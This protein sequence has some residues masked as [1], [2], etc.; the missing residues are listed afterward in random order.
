MAIR[1]HLLR[2]DNPGAVGLNGRV[3]TV[4][5]SEAGRSLL[6]EAVESFNWIVPVGGYVVCTCSPSMGP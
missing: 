5:F 3:W 6:I 1:Y 4:G 2:Q